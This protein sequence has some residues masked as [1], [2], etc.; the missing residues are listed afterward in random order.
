L[1]IDIGNLDQILQVNA[2]N[3]VSSFVQRLGRSGRREGKLAKMFFY[4]RETQHQSDASLGERIPWGLLQMIA[5]IQLYIEEKWIEPPSIPDLPTSLLYHQ[6]MS[7]ITSHT[8]LTPPEIAERVL[9]LSPFSQVTLD[10]Y[11]ELLRYLLE[12]DH[13]EGIDGKGLIVGFAAERLVNN[14]RFYATFEDEISFIVREGTRELGSIQ[15]MPAIGDRFRLAGRAWKV[16]DIDEEKKIVQVEH[17][18]GKAQAFWMGGGADIHTN[19]IKR[20][21]QILEEDKNY[22]YL[23]HRAIHRLAEARELARASNLT[24]QNILALGGR[25]FMV[26]PWQGTKVIRTMRLLLEFQGITVQPSGEPYYF[27]VNI[28]SQDMLKEHIKSICD[29][30]PQPEQLIEKLPRQA[31]QMNKYDRFV[32]ESLL[33]VAY[34]RDYLDIN[35][36]LIHLRHII[37]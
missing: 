21:R 22:G 30:P 2:T 13:L 35:G 17:V 3:T 29:Q 12:T 16:I 26:L 19:I 10:Q 14:Y 20:I 34:C 5:T 23:Q 24:E 36:A 8:E 9:T 6:T 33:R 32:P 37:N 4:S 31:L 1:G 7:I 18:K 25:R 28:S 15:A 27:E 11:R